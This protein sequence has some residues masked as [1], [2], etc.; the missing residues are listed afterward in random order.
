MEILRYLSGSIIFYLVVEYAFGVNHEVLRL[1]YDIFLSPDRLILICLA[2]ALT[3]LVIKRLAN[4]FLGELHPT[5]L[6][7]LMFSVMILPGVLLTSNFSDIGN[8]SFYAYIFS[9]FLFLFGLVTYRY[10]G[11]SDLLFIN[12]S[13][14]KVKIYKIKSLTYILMLVM[15]FIGFVF[16]FSMDNDSKSIYIQLFAFFNG[17]DIDNSLAIERQ[18][19]GT[20]G[21]SFVSVLK[22]YFLTM[23]MPIAAVFIIINGLIRQRKIEIII[24]SL[25]FLIIFLILIKNGSRLKGLSSML[26][27]LVAY[28]YVRPI[29]L[30]RSLDFVQAIVWLLI[31]QTIAL[32]RMSSAASGET[33]LNILYM[34]FNRVVER[35][36][37]TKGYVTQ[38]VFEYIPKD[39]PFKNG[40]TVINDLSGLNSNNL[41]FAQEMF[42]F[43]NNGAINGTAGPQAFGE[44]YANFGLLG[45]FVFA[46]F[47]GIVIQFST[48]FTVKKLIIADAFKIVF[49][50]YF[51]I[52]ITKL[53]YSGIMSFKSNGIHILLIL[54]GCFYMVR[55]IG[56]KLNVR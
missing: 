42:A 11:Q 5:N 23:F 20:E 12:S 15:S 53:S 17:I 33:L 6:F 46:F 3:F 51:V 55:F 54:I 28:S 26:F 43:L 10:L 9:Y 47:T 52:L 31:F 45:M 21:S 44:A 14:K 19:G 24:G 35:V 32:G 49:L 38:K 37:L 56:K 22:V 4:G 1:K 34:S 39:A 29:T 40:Q 50:A 36:I 30:K 2:I 16:I 7:I 25:F 13:Y 27:L 41:S 18:T 48:R 8:L